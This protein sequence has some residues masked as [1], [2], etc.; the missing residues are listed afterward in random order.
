MDNLFSLQVHWLELLH[1]V[2]TFRTSSLNQNIFLDIS[3]ENQKSRRYFLG[4]FPD[5][6]KRGFES[7][8]HYTNSPITLN[9][10]NGILF[11]LH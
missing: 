8:I 6:I 10:N 11:L 9:L 3:S 2:K 1:D 7:I 5:P 4:A